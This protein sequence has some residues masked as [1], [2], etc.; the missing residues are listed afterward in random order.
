[1]FAVAAHRIASVI[2][3]FQPDAVRTA[4]NPFQMRFLTGGALLGL[5]I[6]VPSLASSIATRQWIAAGLIATFAVGQVATLLAI[7]RAVPGWLLLRA[8]VIGLGLFLTLASLTTP[9]MHWE[10]LKWFAL[11][12]L[13]SLAARGSHT[14]EGHQSARTTLV[15][16]TA[17]ALALGALVAVAHALGWTANDVAAGTG[18]DDLLEL[19]DFVLFTASTGGL[20]WIHHLALSRAEEE[21][22]LLRSMLAVCAWCKRIRDEQRGWIDMDHYLARHAQVQLTHGICP[23][24]EHTV[25]NTRTR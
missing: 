15:A 11:L 18:A 3:R 10:Q 22:A 9:T 1:M 14:S 20:L 6:A 19:L 13:V 4:S 5:A 12:P 7:K 8:S 16:S 21:L 25:W 2:D 24:C 17:L 23:D